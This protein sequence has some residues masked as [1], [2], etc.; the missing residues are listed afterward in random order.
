LFPPKEKQAGFQSFVIPL[1]RP[2]AAAFGEV[3]KSLRGSGGNVVVH[4]IL[5][6][7]AAGRVARLALKRIAIRQKQTLAAL[8]LYVWV[9]P[10]KSAL[11]LINQP[12]MDGI[13][14]KFQPVGH[15][16]LIE[17]VMQVIF[18]GL[19]GNEQLLANFLVSESLRHQLH[20]F[21][22]AVR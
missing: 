4:E 12:V 10:S 6:L 17:N 8:A 14:R 22:F 9:D 11:R 5:R 7:Y 3:R 1:A 18:H 2:R 19:L 15:S 21:L 20:N 16:Q 13:Q